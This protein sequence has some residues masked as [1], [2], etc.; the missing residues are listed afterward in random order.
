MP[1]VHEMMESK[2][3]KKEDVDKPVLATIT[4]IDQQNVA[5][6]G[7]EPELKW[8]M[9][10]KELAKP[11]VLN[12]TNLQLCAKAFDSDD[13]DDWIGKKIGLYHEPNVS[14]GGKLVGGIRVK[15]PRT[16]PPVP[17]QKAERKPIDPDD[18]FGDMEN[19]IPF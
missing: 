3:L 19:D 7:A 10:F 5:M 6:N 14:F 17:V 12:P 8:C 11:L 2:F 18:P 9:H 15:K 4:H 1:R 13:T 16:P